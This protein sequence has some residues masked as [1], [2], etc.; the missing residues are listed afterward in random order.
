MI[1][2]QSPYFYDRVGRFIIQWLQENKRTHTKPRNQKELAY[3]LGKTPSQLSRWIK[4]INDMPAEV[5]DK[6]INH[7]G[8]KSKFFDD[9]FREKSEGPLTELLTKEDL[10]RL[11][12]E[13]NILLA[14]YKTSMLF[15]SDRSRKLLDEQRSALRTNE[16]L[17]DEIEKLRKQLKNAD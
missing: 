15:Y 9:Y 5:V 11:I 12:R 3:M 13:Q 4:G 16:R 8:F 2:K 14:E 10:F 7:F 1:K 17:L 6:M